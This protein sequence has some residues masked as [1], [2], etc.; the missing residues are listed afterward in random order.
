VLAEAPELIEDPGAV[1]PRPPMPLTDLSRTDPDRSP[2]NPEWLGQD[3]AEL[4]WDTGSFRTLGPSG[5][6]DAI[7]DPDAPLSGDLPLGPPPEVRLRPHES[8]RETVLE[9][10]GTGGELHRDPPAGFGLDPF[11]PDPDQP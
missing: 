7:I 2:G 10:G 5:P 4:D 1:D 9:S 8:A 11:A 3:P 6:R